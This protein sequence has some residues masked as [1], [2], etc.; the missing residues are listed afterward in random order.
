MSHIKTENGENLVKHRS[1]QKKEENSATSSKLE[2]EVMETEVDTGKVDFHRHLQPS[3][4]HMLFLISSNRFLIH[5]TT[6][7]T[8][9]QVS[10]QSPGVL[11]Q[12]CPLYIAFNPREYMNQINSN[13]SLSMCAL[14]SSYQ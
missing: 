13:F 2:Q 8:P 14:S 4:R 11:A 7:S 6:L 9:P 1:E 12:S 10:F 3:Q 5:F